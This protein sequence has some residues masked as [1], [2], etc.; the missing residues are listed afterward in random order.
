ARKK[1]FATPWTSS[2]CSYS[3]RLFTQCLPSSSPESESEEE[4]EEESEGEPM[5]E[6]AALKEGLV[7]PSGIASVA[8]TVPS[9]LETPDFIE[10]RKDPRARADDADETPRQL[11][12]VI[13]EVQRNITG[14]MGSQHGYDLSSAKGGPSGAAGTK[15]KIVGEGVEISLDAS[16]LEGLDEE[17]LRRKFEEQQM[18]G[19][20]GAT[21]GVKEDFSDMVAEHANKQAK[22]RKKVEEVKK[23]GKKG[24][25]FK[26]KYDEAE[27]LYQRVLSHSTN[28]WPVAKARETREFSTLSEIMLG[29]ITL[30]SNFVR[31][32]FP[33]G[34]LGR[35]ARYATTSTTNNRPPPSLLVQ[36]LE[37]AGIRR[38]P[39]CERPVYIPFTIAEAA[40]IQYSQSFH[41][42]TA[43]RAIDILRAS[44]PIALGFD[45]ETTVYR[46]KSPGMISLIQLATPDACFMIQIFRITDGDRT[47]FPP[48]LAT[49][50]NSSIILKVGCKATDDA[51]HLETSYGVR[52]RGAID[53]EMLAR[54]K[55]FP[56]SSLAEMSQIWGG[57]EGVLIK[58]VDVKE[59]KKLLKWNFDARE[60]TD[61]VVE[62]SSRDAFMGLQIFINILHGRENTK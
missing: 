2:A 28:G 50:L 1:F 38:A 42:I 16:E 55:G 32:E 6:D 37:A 43:S 21:A 7:T 59:R 61:E 5:V 35:I 58:P 30:R 48:I 18:Q 14:L 19:V 29:I 34:T 41:P 3:D 57:E 52:V 31:N 33:F 49:L 25:E 40:S 12:T 39:W 20:E 23:E 10:L 8:S 51:V 24:K 15:R 36:Q 9:G 53:I 4:S 27:S 11:Y 26:G 17:T 45:T 46:K 44:R 47:L 60:L 22:K 13:P 54:A 62:Y 56:V